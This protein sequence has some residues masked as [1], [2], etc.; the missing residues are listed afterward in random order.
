MENDEAV[1]DRDELLESADGDSEMLG[2]MAGVFVRDAAELLA[3]IDAA[4]DNADS[5]AART[6]THTLKGMLLTVA[7]RPAAAIA[8][9]LEQ[10]LDPGQLEVAA[11]VAQQL[12]T[13]TDEVAQALTAVAREEGAE[14]ATT[15]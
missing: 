7:A 1:V 10:L 11:T 9:R 14:P 6:A 13:A 4:L 12:A 15:D 3:Q 5:A 8:V 2:W